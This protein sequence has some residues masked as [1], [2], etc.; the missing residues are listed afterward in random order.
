MELIGDKFCVTKT[1]S[2]AINIGDVLYVLATGL[3]AKTTAANQYNV[4]G[5]ANSGAAAGDFVNIITNGLANVV[6]SEV[7][8]AGDLV[9]SAADG[10]V[11]KVTPG[12]THTENTNITYTQNATTASA[13]EIAAHA[14]IG[15]ALG[16]TTAAG[17]TLQILLCL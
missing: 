1:A 17:E 3:V 16:T 6:C 8:S 11:A 2:G 13:T 7:I 9:G 5:V 10:R 14:K 12:H 4:V 15:K